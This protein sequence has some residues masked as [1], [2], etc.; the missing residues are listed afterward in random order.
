[1]S[2]GQSRISSV[3]VTGDMV[4]GTTPSLE[5]RLRSQMGTSE[6]NYSHLTQGMSEDFG[7]RPLTA[8][9][10]VHGRSNMSLLTHNLSTTGMESAG[11]H[12]VN[13]SSTLVTYSQVNRYV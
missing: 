10:R 3:N 7:G 11:G 2:V 4:K 1:M 6:G 8:S 13:R 12:G 5:P 9:A